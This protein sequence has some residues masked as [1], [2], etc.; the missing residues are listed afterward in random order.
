MRGFGQRG[1]SGGVAIAGL[2]G[3]RAPGDGPMPDAV[4]M[5]MG[6]LIQTLE[7]PRSPLD[8]SSPPPAAPPPPRG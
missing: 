2:P 7:R 3:L 5:L 6:Q 8:P 1:L 4:A